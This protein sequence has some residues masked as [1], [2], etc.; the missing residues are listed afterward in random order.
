MPLSHAFE[1]TYL[2][3]ERDIDMVCQTYKSR[4]F[5]YWDLKSEANLSFC[6]AYFSFQSNR[7]SFKS[8]VINKIRYGILEYI[9]REQITKKRDVFGRTLGDA[10]YN[11]ED[12]RVGAYHPDLEFVDRLS[13]DA[14]YIVILVFDTPRP[15]MRI[16]S[17]QRRGRLTPLNFKIALR[18]YLLKLGWEEVRIRDTFSEIRRALR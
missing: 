6:R 7:S 8:W 5:P 12:Y 4:R 17:K 2:E 18:E 1:Q 10:D 3:V 15:L 11:V 9:R 14:K 16:L 13:N